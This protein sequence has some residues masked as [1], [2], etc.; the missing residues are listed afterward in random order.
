MGS[1]YGSVWDFRVESWDAAG[2]SQ[3]S[4][5]VEMRG[6]EI[7]GSVGD[8]DWV[9]IQGHWKP[10]EVFIVRSLT[11]LSQ[12]A[13]VVVDGYGERHPVKTLTKIFIIL[14]GLGIFVVIAFNF[15]GFWGY[16]W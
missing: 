5:A 15:R 13:Q 3:Q 6:V 11:N 14:V 2:V 10:G 16:F 4:V 9:E 12:N 7:K 1:R 8:G